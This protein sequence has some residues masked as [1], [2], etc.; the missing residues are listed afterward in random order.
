M[1]QMKFFLVALMAVVMGMSVTS[2]MNGD[3]NTQ[4]NDR[5][6]LGKVKDS[7]LNLTFTS[8]DGYTFKSK[9]AVEGTTNLMT[10]DFIV[11]SCTYDTAVD[12]D[13]TTNTINAT[14]GS[15]EKISGN[16]VWQTTK[17]NDEGENPDHASNRGVISISDLTPFMVDNYNLLIPIQYFAFEKIASHTFSL[18][19]YSDEEE[20]KGKS[21][22]KLFLRHIS[23]EEDEKETYRAF[24]YRVFDISNALQAYRTL[25]DNKYPSNITIVAET[26][27]SNNDVPKTTTTSSVTY[28][29]KE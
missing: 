15:V 5:P 18:V 29:F 2:C 27:S 10:N 1:K 20:L 17:A 6:I 3:D 9:N 8:L 22:L 21:D 14:I 25:N 16:S 4:V 13:P 7:F 12:I 19:Y 28:T 24:S 23:T 11:A 26:N